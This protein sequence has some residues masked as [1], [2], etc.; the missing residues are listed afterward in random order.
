MVDVIRYCVLMFFMLVF[1]VAI[2]NLA[3]LLVAEAGEAKADEIGYLGCGIKPIPPIGCTFEDAV[4]ICS[5]NGN[6]QW[7]YA[8]R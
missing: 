1:V 7:I 3:L 5:A 4:C 2:S 8:C 6:C